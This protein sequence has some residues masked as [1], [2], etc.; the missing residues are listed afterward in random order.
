[1]EA[2]MGVF[3]M[4]TSS[5]FFA[6]SGYFGK[7]VVNTTQ[8]NAVVTSFSRYALGAIIMIFYMLIKK[9]SFV[10][11]KL[12]P[13]TIRSIFNAGAVVLATLALN[14]TTLTNANILHLTYPVFVVILAPFITKEKPKIS[15]YFYLILILAGSYIISNPDL[16]NINLGD[17]AAFASAIFAGLSILYLT[18]ARK[19][20]SGSLI[21]LYLMVIGTFINGP[22]VIKDL[23]LIDINS[24]GI[25]L[26]AALFGFFGQVFTTEGY[27]YLDSATGS[28]LSTSRILF[29]T[30]LGFFFLSEP[31]NARI[32]IGICIT[33]VAL[34]GV[35]GYFKFP[36]KSLS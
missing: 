30:L 3:Y 11:N 9:K 12:G 36:K 19:T 8:M 34:I 21:V 1:M 25:V 18:E 24:V 10:A 28:I 27:R 22:L 17:L 14:Y 33:M 5:V 7:L 23:G 32:I 15:A 13:V 31:L 35:S 4:L 20:E 2:K 6:L 16:S 26:M 29:A